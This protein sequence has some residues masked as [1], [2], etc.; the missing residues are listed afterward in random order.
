MSDVKVSKWYFRVCVREG[1][2]GFSDDDDFM[3]KKYTNFEDCYA[4]YLNFSPFRYWEHCRRVMKQEIIYCYG[5]KVMLNPIIRGT[6]R[7]EKCEEDLGVTKEEFD[8]VMNK[9][10]DAET[11]DSFPSSSD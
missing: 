5:N 10:R 6:I 3:S 9:Y 2:P 8:R 11:Q 7:F 4:G 1:R